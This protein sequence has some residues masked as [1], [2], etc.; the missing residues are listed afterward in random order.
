MGKIRP[1]LIRYWLH[2]SEK[3]EHP[4]NFAQKVNEICSIYENAIEAAENGLHTVSVDE[5]TGIFRHW[6]IN[7]LTNRSCREKLPGRILS[8]YIME[9]P[10]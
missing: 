7:I 4:E 8:T 5:M 6:S 9:Q 10:V 3:T 1:H 2:S